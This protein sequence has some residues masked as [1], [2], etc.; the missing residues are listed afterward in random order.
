MNMLLGPVPKCWTLP[1]SVQPLSGS[2]PFWVQWVH[3]GLDPSIWIQ[4]W[5]HL[6]LELYLGD[7][8]YRYDVMEIRHRYQIWWQIALPSNDIT[9]PRNRYQ[10]WWDTICPSNDIT[11]T[12]FDG[13]I[14][15]IKWHHTHLDKGK[16]N[17]WLSISV[18]SYPIRKL[19]VP[20]ESIPLGLSK[21][22][23][24]V[25]IHCSHPCQNVF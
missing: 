14:M 4:P 10:I 3:S 18:S 9:D 12:G 11:G 23:H 7:T 15:S 21:F 2:G 17:S 20:L 13:Q 24:G 22:V 5:P 8:K 19:W 6:C 16:Q 1:G 25:G